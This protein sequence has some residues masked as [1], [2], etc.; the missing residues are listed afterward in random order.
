MSTTKETIKVIAK[1]AEGHTEC[2]M[3]DEIAQHISD[4]YEEASEFHFDED[5]DFLI[6]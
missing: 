4:Y 3:I 1:G 5:T 6:H 2:P